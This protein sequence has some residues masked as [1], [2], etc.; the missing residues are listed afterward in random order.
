MFRKQPQQPTPPSG[1]NPHVEANPT[2]QIQ[3]SLPPQPTPDQFGIDPSKPPQTQK[4]D[5][6]RS[7]LQ[8][9]AGQD[10]PQS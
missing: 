5:K 8:Q 7:I 3:Q 9:V 4:P 2:V 10:A 1:A 6:S